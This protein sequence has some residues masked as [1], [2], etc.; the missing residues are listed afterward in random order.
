[1][2]IS[3][4][5][6]HTYK[7]IP[8]DAQVVSHQLMVRSGMIKKL[9][10]GIYTYMPMLLRTIRKIEGII[11]EEM[12]KSGAIELLMPMVLPAELWIE[13]GRWSYY[14]AELL[15]FKDRKGADFCLGPTH[16]EII[17]DIAR[18]ELKSYKDLPKNLYQIQTKFRDEARPRFGLMRGREFLMKDAYSFHTTEEDAKREYW[19]MY[20][21]Y[22]RIFKRCGLKFRAVSAA[23]GNIG[24][25]LSHEFQV[26]A[27]SGEDEI[28]ACNQCDYA[29]NVEM[30]ACHFVENPSVE[31]SNK[32][33]EVET[34]NKRTV[35]EVCR[36]L[37]VIPS[38]LIKTIL[39]IADGKPYA[40]LVRGDF[41]I[42]ESKVKALLKCDELR[43]AND[44]EI[45]DI[46]KAPVGF[47]GPIGLGI[48][49]FADYSVKGLSGAVVGAN[50]ADTHLKGVNVERDI[51]DIK[52]FYDIRFAKPGEICPQCRKG[53]YERFRGI[54][55]GQIFYLGTK[56]SARMNAE[57]LDRDGQK[58]PM[59][60][61]CYGIGIG[62]TAAAAI[63]QYHDKDGIIWPMPIAPFEV[64][65]MCIGT[66]SEEVV[67]RG[68]E[69][70]KKLLSLNVEV[71]F[72]DRDERP[73]VLFKDADLIGIP[74][75]V[76]VSK[77]SIEKGGVEVKLRREK[78]SQIVPFERFADDIKRL[79]SEEYKYYSGGEGVQ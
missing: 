22:V 13:S 41:D 43:L 19:N 79:I 65:L 7:E 76:S 11:R 58:K 70:Y 28:L 63:E 10:A 53:I 54:E 56:Y 31:S 8:S 12:N 39:Y 47:A 33:T 59:I 6:F 50:K 52:G 37:D 68:E 74:I 18:Q 42:N 24:G 40:F 5:M 55:V 57:F 16:E 17:T 51:K 62:R 77:K 61:G 15:R 21:T 3:K 36:F 75:R 20:E 71:L 27:D 26:L 72:D 29:A 34:P 69:L 35:E 1:M 60:M 30:A 49:I 23:T 25:T 32:Y 44:K 73:G 46:T 48:D 4:Y 2:R 78:A 38:R 67:R 66:D 14:G 9:S 64:H 45:V